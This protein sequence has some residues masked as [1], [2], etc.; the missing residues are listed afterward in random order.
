MFP[1]IPLPMYMKAVLNQPKYFSTCRRTKKSKSNVKKKWMILRI[2]ERKVGGEK[3]GKAKEK[4]RGEGKE[5]RNVETERKRGG[6]KVETQRRI[7]R[8]CKSEE[9][10]VYLGG[11]L[12]S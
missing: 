12:S 9:S 6:G 2:Q 1:P 10:N 7:G 8:E 4:K 3:G 11:S 5:R